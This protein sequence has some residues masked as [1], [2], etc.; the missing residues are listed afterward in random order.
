MAGK[1]YSTTLRFWTL[2]LPATP[3]FAAVREWRRP[4]P[5]EEA[6]AV[7]GDVFLL[8]GVWRV[9]GGVKVAG[10]IPKRAGQLAADRRNAGFS[11][12]DRV[13][14]E[15]ARPR[16]LAVDYSIADRK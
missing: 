11:P 13:L 15:F 4:T 1:P 7:V 10:R 9:S 16:E 6:A 5:Q 2:R 12:P 8:R 14:T 3:N